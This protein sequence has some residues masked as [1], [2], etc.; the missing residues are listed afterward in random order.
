MII[1]G[2]PISELE[3]PAITICSQ[4]WISGVTQGAMNYQFLTY[5]ESKG[6]NLSDLTDDEVTQLKKSL[7][8]G[9]KNISKNNRRTHLI[10]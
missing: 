4:G 5:A 6:H 9:K 2:L 1:L 3:Y 7:L 10:P 8:S